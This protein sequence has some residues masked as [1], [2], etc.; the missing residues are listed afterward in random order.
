MKNIAEGRY[1]LLVVKCMLLDGC[2]RVNERFWTV[3]LE[4]LRKR[5]HAL[6]DPQRMLAPLYTGGVARG[7]HGTSQRPHPT[8]D[9]LCASRNIS[10]GPPSV[11]LSLAWRPF[12]MTVDK[13]ISKL[14]PARSFKKPK[15]L[16]VGTKV[17]AS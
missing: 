12:R 11:L 6:R 1:Q 4:L 2:G 10:A 9:A 3:S 15:S 16:K 8:V 13:P 14:D 7:Q 17:L 5:N